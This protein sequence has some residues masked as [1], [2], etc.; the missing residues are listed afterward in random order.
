MGIHYCVDKRKTTHILRHLVYRHNLC[1]AR[2]M[3]GRPVLGSIV[4]ANYIT[5]TTDSKTLSTEV[6][7][8]ICHLLC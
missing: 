1:F 4:I 6:K 5:E 7:T 3:T 8:K 2:M